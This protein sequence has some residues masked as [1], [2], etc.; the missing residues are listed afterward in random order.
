MQSE[1]TDKNLTF[2][3]VI[4]VIDAV[5]SGEVDCLD[6]EIDDRCMM[7]LYRDIR[8]AAKCMHLSCWGLGVRKME[9]NNVQINFIKGG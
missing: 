1:Y 4:P 5:T 9:V 2:K 3:G 6:I 7:Q 8:F